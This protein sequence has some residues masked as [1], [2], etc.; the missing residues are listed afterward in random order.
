MSE[1]KVVMSFADLLSWTQ[2]PEDGATRVEL[3]RLP[4]DPNLNDRVAFV[5]CGPLT[6]RLAEYIINGL[7]Q[8]NQQPDVAAQQE[9][10]QSRGPELRI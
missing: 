3:L 2:A 6:E 8:L 4:K 1:I 5:I 9:D 10:S 7:A